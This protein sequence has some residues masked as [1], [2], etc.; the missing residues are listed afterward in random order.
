MNENCP[1]DSFPPPLP[2]A[3]SNGAK[4]QPAKNQSAPDKQAYRVLVANEQASLAIDQV[5]LT[6][7]AR[8]ILAE[9]DYPSATVS[10][11]VV[12]DPTMHALNVQYL[13]HD[14]PTDV[15]S[16]VLEE[17]P[18]CVEGELVVSTDTAIREAPEAG[19]T[20]SDEL[21]LYVIH[22]T[23]HLI[24][25]DDHEPADQVEMYTAEAHYLQRMG[26]ALPNDASRWP[27]A[28]KES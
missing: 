22:G 11:A 27:V 28:R 3:D 7:A 26:L 24:G 17:S 10:I 5:R 4:N 19:W 1:A 23:L 14:Y 25:Y 2:H 12:D 18:E 15:L 16:F 8:M 21:L 6:A 9:S 13:K 20:A